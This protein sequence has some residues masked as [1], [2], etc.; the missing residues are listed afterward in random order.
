MVRQIVEGELV[1]PL[2]A[3]SWVSLSINHNGAVF[4]RKIVDLL[5]SKGADV[6]VTYA[7]DI[8]PLEIGLK[9][10]IPA[11]VYRLV[12]A[13]A[14]LKKKTRPYYLKRLEDCLNKVKENICTQ[15]DTWYS[16]HHKPF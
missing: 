3:L 16:V 1:V 10:P 8:G 5:I 2:A 9:T 4:F 7:D 11:I 15:V 12:C 13:G 6:N 14:K